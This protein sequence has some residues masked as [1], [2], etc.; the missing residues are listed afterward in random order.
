MAQA[1]LLFGIF[2]VLYLGF[3]ALAMS[4]DRHWQRLSGDK[5]CPRRTAIALRAVGWMLLG[6]GLVLALLRDGGGFGTLLFGTGISI[7]ALAVV[8][9]LTWQASLLRPLARLARNIG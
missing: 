3:A 9:T 4:Q 6:T 7:G 2:L 1:M 5:Q 8:A